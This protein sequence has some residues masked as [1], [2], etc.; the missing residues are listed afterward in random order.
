MN[1]KR[2]NF[3]FVSC[4]E[5]YLEKRKEKR[6]SIDKKLLKWI[7]A[8][9]LNPILVTDI[10]QIYYFRYL[11]PLGVILSGGNDIDELSDRFKI[12]KKL[13]LW[14]KKNKKPILGICHGLQMLAYLNKAKLKKIKN[15]VRI[16]HPIISKEKNFYPKVVNSFHNLGLFKAPNNFTVTAYAPDDSIEAIRHKKYN[17]EGWMWHPERDKKFDIKLILRAKKIFRNK[18]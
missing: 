18:V 11:K 6:F 17:W 7:K 10:D 4:R 2:K 16:R 13:I 14:A 8:V 15:H 1:S 5:D 3:V 9:N 12:E